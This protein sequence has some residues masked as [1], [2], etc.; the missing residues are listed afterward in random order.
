MFKNPRIPE[1]TLCD[2]CQFA[3]I[4]TLATH[5]KL[6]EDTGWGKEYGYYCDS[7]YEKRQK[8]DRSGQCEWCKKESDDLRW[9]KDY[10]EGMSEPMYRVCG[11]CDEA[12]QRAIESELKRSGY[13]DEY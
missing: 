2:S 3:G 13:Y 4:E 6:E 8:K 7:C 9:V 11:R 10:N 5:R 12:Q 1:G